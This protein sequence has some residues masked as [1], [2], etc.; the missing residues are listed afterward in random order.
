MATYIVLMNWTAKG[1]QEAKGAP[2][3]AE[4][5]RK[6]AQEMGGDLKAAY[7]VMGR[8]DFVAILE[9]PNDETMARFAVRIAQLGFS[10]TETL[11]AFTEAEFGQILG[12]L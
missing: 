3:R 6:A 2:A 10:E 4:A 5:A 7:M 8:F 11:R 1:A 12:S 9:L